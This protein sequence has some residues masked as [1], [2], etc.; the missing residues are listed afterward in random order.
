LFIGLWLQCLKKKRRAT[1]FRTV[2]SRPAPHFINL[3]PALPAREA[4][5]TEKKV[6]RRTDAERNRRPPF[7]FIAYPVEPNAL[8][9]PQSLVVITACA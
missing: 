5:P 7:P 8:P 9:Q 1:M 4:L 6:G 2:R 3:S